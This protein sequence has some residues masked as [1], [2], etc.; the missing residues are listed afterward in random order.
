MNNNN[1]LM[2]F[3]VFILIDSDQRLMQMGP[4][5]SAD[6]AKH[7][8]SVFRKNITIEHDINIVSFSSWEKYTEFFKS[9]TIDHYLEY[10]G[11]RLTDAE[12]YALQ[13]DNNDDSYA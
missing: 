11:H 8:I 12:R 7:F 1:D 3:A 9:Y 2:F 4:F 10:I 6:D 5:K 13:G